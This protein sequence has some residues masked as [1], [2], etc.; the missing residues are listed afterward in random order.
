M[1]IK[2]PNFSYIINRQGDYIKSKFIYCD[3]WRKSTTRLRYAGEF[4]NWDFSIFLKWQNRN[5]GNPKIGFFLQGLK[6][7]L[8]TCFESK[9]FLSWAEKS[10]SSLFSNAVL[11]QRPK[12][13]GRSRRFK[14]YGY[15]G[16]SFRQFLRP[17]VL[18][19][20]FLFFFQNGG[21]N[22]FFITQVPP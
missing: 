13:Y 15:G 8:K 2:C 10:G 5:W 7:T 17:K 9:K 19:V 12:F 20:V 11:Y 1:S 22:V 21:W 18:L 6:Y 3:L 4:A 14:T 16:W